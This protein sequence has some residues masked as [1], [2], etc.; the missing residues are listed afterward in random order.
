[1]KLPNYN[2]AYN[3]GDQLQLLAINDSERKQENSCSAL[4]SLQFPL[5]KEITGTSYLNEKVNYLL[6]NREQWWSLA[7]IVRG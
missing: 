6:I 3:T 1:M 4:V 2:L 7:K 5:M